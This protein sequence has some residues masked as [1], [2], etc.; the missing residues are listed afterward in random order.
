MTAPRESRSV[1][2]KH[3]V[4]RLAPVDHPDRGTVG[5]RIEEDELRRIGLPST[6]DRVKHG[7]LA[8]PI[9]NAIIAAVNEGDRNARFDQCRRGKFG[10]R[11]PAQQDHAG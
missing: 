10:V 1:R 5:P 9:V 11:H 4:E 8:L 2:G 7:A 3:A 6:L